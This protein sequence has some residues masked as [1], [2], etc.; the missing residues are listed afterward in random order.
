M[1]RQIAARGG[2]LEEVLR[3]RGG[4]DDDVVADGGIQKRMIMGV[5][6]LPDL[7]RELRIRQLSVLGIDRLAPESEDVADGKGGAGER[8]ED[9]GSG[10]GVVDVDADRRRVHPAIAIPHDELGIEHAGFRKL[11]GRLGVGRID[12][13]VVVEVPLVAEVG[14]IAIVGVDRTGTVKANSQWQETNGLI[15]RN[16]SLGIAVAIAG[17][18]DAVDALPVAS[19]RQMDEVVQGLLGALM[20]TELQTDDLL[21]LVEDLL[22]ER[23]AGW[24]ALGEIALLGLVGGDEVDAAPGGKYGIE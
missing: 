21:V 23:R 10:R 20:G 5:V 16:D 2:Q 12:P 19:R 6:M 15:C 18:A 9:L 8:A 1:D 3:R 17:E 11:E 14:G 22:L 4:V 7:P 24:V 13:A